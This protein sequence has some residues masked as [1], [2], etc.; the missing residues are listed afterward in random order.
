MD[1]STNYLGMTLKNPTGAILFTVDAKR[2]KA[3]RAMEDAGASAVVLHSLF[4]EQITQE[5]HTLNHYLTQGVESHPE[6]LNY[7]PEASEYKNWTQLNIWS[8][9]KK[10]K[11]A[12]DIPVIASLNGVFN[13]W[14]GEIR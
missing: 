4:E 7:F 6:A 13:R 2:W 9:F 10:Q 3:L 12:L 14:L 11:R 8:I 5:S 1:L